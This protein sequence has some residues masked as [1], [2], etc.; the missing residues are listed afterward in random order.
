M[1]DWKS[2]V[3]SWWNALHQEGGI[4]WQDLE[5]TFPFKDSLKACPQDT[6]FHAE[7][8]VWTHTCMVLD[9]LQKSL[10]FQELSL[11]QQFALRLAALFHDIAKPECTMIEWDEE[12]QRKRVRQPHHARKGAQKT[13]NVLTRLGIPSS[14][15]QS[16]YWLILWHQRPFHIWSTDEMLRRAISFSVLGNWKELLCLVEADNN[17]RISTQSEDARI[18]GILLKEW[19]QEYN[20]LDEAWS[21]KNSESR[22][23]YFEKEHR[24][25]YY[26]ELGDIGST[27]ILLCGL[28]GAGKDFY[29]KRNF[30]DIPQISLDQIRSKMGFVHGDNQGAAIQ[31]A[32]EQARVFLRKKQN[33]I[34]NATNLTVQLRA[35]TISL[36]RSYKAKVV[37]HVLDRPFDLICEQNKNRKE[38]IPHSALETILYKFEPP[39][40]LEAHEVHWVS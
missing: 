26:E 37:I 10:S 40:L 27:V 13:W 29:A 3:P 8:D 19:L 17:G 39:S 33:F 23:Q 2:N 21:F 9:E 4:H 35:K 18:N 15:K 34:W 14:L 7:G 31:E 11:N 25:P 20:L 24:S 6:V 28:A 32:Y 30:P 16:V 12:L 5:N 36:L 1:G 22:M 38:S